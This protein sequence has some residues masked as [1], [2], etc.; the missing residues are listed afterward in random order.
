MGNSLQTKWH[1]VPSA[2]EALRSLL[3]ERGPSPS[4]QVYPFVLGEQAS[5]FLTTDGK[6]APGLQLERALLQELPG[7][8]FC[9]FPP[10]VPAPPGRRQAAEGLS[11][12]LR[13]LPLRGRRGR[14]G[15]GTE[16]KYTL[17]LGN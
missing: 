1:C 4:Q 15:E 10:T 8:V 9:R 5:S 14:E 11:C 17:H 2:R 16:V 3:G 13:K 12:L 7:K 6:R